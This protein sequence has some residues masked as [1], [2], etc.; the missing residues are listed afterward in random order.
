MCVCVCVY[1]ACGLGILVPSVPPSSVSWFLPPRHTWRE[2][3]EPPSHLLKM[4]EAAAT[5]SQA[6]T[7]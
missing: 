7:V 5:E 3:V 2:K 4:H 1:T 6:E